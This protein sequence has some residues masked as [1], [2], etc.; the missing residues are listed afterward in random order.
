MAGYTQGSKMSWR[1]WDPEFQNVKGQS[2]VVFDKERNAHMLCQHE[3]NEI[4]IFGLPEDEK[5]VDEPDTG[6]EPLRGHDSQP[7]KIGKRSRSHMHEAPDEAAETI[8]HRRNFRQEDQTAQR[9]TAD[10]ENI[11]HS[12]RL[13]REDLT[14]RRSG[15][16]IKKASQLPPASPA[17]PIASR[18]TRSQ[19]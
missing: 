13:R 2:E 1:I 3:S 15:A 11:A 16:A 10:A 18:V 14:A 9:S 8:A 7:T 6:G 5:Y 19:G 12:W 17:L 4:D